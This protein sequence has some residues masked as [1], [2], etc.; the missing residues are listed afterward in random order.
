MIA[1]EIESFQSI[2]SLKF[3]IDGFTAVVGGSDLGKSAIVRALKCALTGAA[4]TDFVRHGPL[5]ERRLKNTKKCRCKATVRISTP[6]FSF[7]W[8]K[9]DS[10]NKYTVYHPDRPDEVYDRVGHGAPDFLLPSFNPVKIGDN[11]VLLQVADQFRVAGVGGPIFLLDVTGTAVAEAISDVARLDALNEAMKLVQR[12][13]KDASSTRTVRERDL[14]QLREEL[15]TYAGLDGVLAR[16]RDIEVKQAEV[17]KARAHCE[18][19][20]GIVVAFDTI[21]DVI[22]ALHKLLQHKLPD[23]EALQAKQA[24]FFEVDKLLTEVLQRTPDVKRLT[25]I[26]KIKI[27]EEPTEKVTAAFDKLQQH[28]TKL[29]HFEALQAREAAVRRD[30]EQGEKATKLTV[31]DF[32]VVSDALTKFDAVRTLFDRNSVLSGEIAAL[33]ETVTKAEQ[34]EAQ[35]LAELKELG[36]CPTCSGPIGSETHL[37][38]DEAS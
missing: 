36:L 2:E 14:L 28:D 25:G 6:T 4:G 34:E 32:V 22:R 1:V 18:K 21:A 37:H 35:V 11:Q 15:E 10:V 24:R 27:P 17:T 31:A 29:Q 20:A 12:D 38:F 5:C 23:E 9:G 7:K 26:D 13:R 3:T 8:E 19:V 30:I 33:E 16:A